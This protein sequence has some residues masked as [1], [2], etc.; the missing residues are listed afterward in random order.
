MSK[1]MLNSIQNCSGNSIHFFRVLL[2][3]KEKLNS[4]PN[5]Q[6]I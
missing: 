5:S 4:I 1:K 6:L 3:N 2:I